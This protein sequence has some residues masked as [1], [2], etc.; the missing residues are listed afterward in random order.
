MLTHK[1]PPAPEEEKDQEK[2]P[3]SPKQHRLQQLIAS[4]L[5]EKMKELQVAVEQEL[6]SHERKLAE[7]ISALEATVEGKGK[8]KKK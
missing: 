3:P 4:S 1:E 7:R 8:G 5:S 2:P 6:N